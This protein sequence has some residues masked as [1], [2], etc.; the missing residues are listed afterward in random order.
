[1]FENWFIYIIQCKDGKL[2]TGIAKDVQKRIALHNK[3]LACR[4]T[5][6]RNPVHLLY[7]EEFLSKSSARL[8]EIELKGYSQKKKLEIIKRGSSA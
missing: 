2:Y 6:Y 4:F 5:K 1:M 8:R 7:T 3:G